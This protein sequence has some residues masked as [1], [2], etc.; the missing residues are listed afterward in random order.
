M[1]KSQFEMEE[2]SSINFNKKIWI[3]VDTINSLL[4][5][6]KYFFFLSKKK[7]ET[8]YYFFVPFQ[9][10]FNSLNFFLFL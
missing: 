5:E 3:F 8:F 7:L 4:T 9:F 10:L 6:I 2:T 1:S